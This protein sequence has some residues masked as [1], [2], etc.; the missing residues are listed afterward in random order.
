MP[1]RPTIA[2]IIQDAL[3]ARFEVDADGKAT[4]EDYLG[5]PT[6][7]RRKG[8]ITNEIEAAV[9]TLGAC[10]YVFPAR[11][12]RVNKNLP[13][14]YASS[15]LV[16]F[17]VIENPALNELLPDAYELAEMLLV[18]FSEYDLRAVEGLDGINPLQPLEDAIEEQPDEERV[19]FDVTF[20]TSVGL[21]ASS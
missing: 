9:A 14:P 1:R 4:L 16:R 5:V 20:E 10:I 7:G 6:L 13:G 21:P 11:V 12:R 19:I 2:K 3:V 8:I 18:D 17:R 15:V